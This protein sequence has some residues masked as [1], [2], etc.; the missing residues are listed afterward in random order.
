MNDG[1]LGSDPATVDLTVNAVNTAPVANAQSVTTDKN[2][3]KEITLTGSDVDGNTLTFIKGTGPSHGTL[4]TISSSGVVTYTPTTGYVG[5]DSFTFTVNDGFLGSNPAT[6]DI[7]V[8]DAQSAGPVAA[9]RAED[10]SVVRQNQEAKFIDKSVGSSLTYAWDFGDGSTSSE[11]NPAHIY[12]KEGVYPVTLTVSNAL[13][14]DTITK[15]D[16]LWVTEPNPLKPNFDAA[17][18]G[19]SS[20]LMVQFTDSSKVSV[21]MPSYPVVN[22]WTWDF[23]DDSVPSTEQN[24][25]HSYAQAGQL[26]RYPDYKQHG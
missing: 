16:Y 14:S 3:A 24:P 7:T 21:T 9:F 5:T 18:K 26:Y 1:F 12:K 6:V 19:G 15:K 13:G 2:V 17:K 20:P 4:G 11:Q 23:G 22:S 25:T 8:N 10:L